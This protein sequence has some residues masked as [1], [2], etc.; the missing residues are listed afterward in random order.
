MTGKSLHRI[1]LV[2]IAASLA[3]FIYGIIVIDDEVHVKM[4]AD[5]WQLNKRHVEQH[6]NILLLK[7]GVVNNHT[8]LVQD[9]TEIHA[10]A[11]KIIA[12]KP[13]MLLIYRVGILGFWRINEEKFN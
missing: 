4:H 2:F 12:V 7:N 13:E 1:A 9:S 10:L 8:G 5:L 6:K 3:F 11:S